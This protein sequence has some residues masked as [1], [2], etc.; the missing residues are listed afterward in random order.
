MLCTCVG[1][2]GAPGHSQIFPVLFPVRFVCMSFSENK[3]TFASVFPNLCAVDELSHLFSFRVV[4]RLGLSP[5]YG[6][7]FSG[8]VSFETPTP[9][10]HDSAS[11]LKVILRSLIRILRRPTPYQNCLAHAPP[12]SALPPSSGYSLYQGVSIQ[13][14]L[15]SFGR[16][17]SSGLILFSPPFI[18]DTP[19]PSCALCSYPCLYPTYQYPTTSCISLPPVFFFDQVFFPTPDLSQPIKD[20]TC[21]Q[22]I[23]AMARRGV[24]HRSVL[25]LATD[26]SRPGSFLFYGSC[27]PLHSFDAEVAPRLPCAEP[28]LPFFYV[29]FVSS[30]LSSPDFFFSSRSSL[31][32]IFRE[33]DAAIECSLRIRRL[34]P[35]TVLPDTRR[36]LLFPQV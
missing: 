27:A 20:E 9:S 29:R 36:F 17:R 18:L 30:S 35:W 13:V 3:P 19:V 15:D 32:S 25:S 6:V 5:L 2:Q 23:R 8:C 22:G 28:L 31:F 11:P 4:L 26:S 24:G 1:V 10:P 14:V 16:R 33:P 7:F 21:S 12:Y 34:L